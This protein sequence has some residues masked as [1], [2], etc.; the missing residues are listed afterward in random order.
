MKHAWQRSFKMWVWRSYVATF[1]EHGIQTLDDFYTDQF[2][3][4]VDLYDCY[5][6]A[7]GRGGFVYQSH[8]FDAKV[9]EESRTNDKEVLIKWNMECKF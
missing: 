4:L 2:Y 7:D 3:D 6:V 9:E 8:F 1:Q 5:G